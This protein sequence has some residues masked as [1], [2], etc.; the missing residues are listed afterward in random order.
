[1][2]ADDI[3]SDSKVVFSSA[4]HIAIRS[5]DL[6]EQEILIMFCSDGTYM[7]TGFNDNRHVQWKHN[8]EGRL[9]YCHKNEA[10]QYWGK[11]EDDDQVPRI[12]SDWIV[13]YTILR[14]NHE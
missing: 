12:V 11:T 2:S 5:L 8:E 3:L 4:T 9:L 1:M 10:W 6:D 7:S 13:E 14:S